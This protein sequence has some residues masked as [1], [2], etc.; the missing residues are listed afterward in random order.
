MAVWLRHCAAQVKDAGSIPASEAVF[1][2]EAENENDRV[3]RF[4][5]TSKTPRWSKL[6][7][8]SPLLGA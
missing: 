7:R 3:S 4:W 5:R 2:M 8:V 6:I 1:L